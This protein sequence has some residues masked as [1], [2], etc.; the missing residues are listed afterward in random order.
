MNHPHA[1][2]LF[3]VVSAL[4]VL[5]AEPALADARC[6]RLA[7]ETEAGFE[8]AWP[9]V[10]SRVHSAFDARTDTDACARVRLENREAAIDLEVVL[11]DGRSARRSELQPEDVVPVLEGL[12]V[13]PARPFVAELP[14]MEASAGDRDPSPVQPGVD[15]ESS[16]EVVQA[17]APPPTFGYEFSLATQAR[18]GDGQI[19]AGFGASSVLE[20]ASF[21]VGLAARYDGYRWTSGGDMV[22]ALEVAA[23]GGYRFRLK[24][25]AL[26]VYGGPAWTRLQTSASS[27]APIGS[28]AV[29]PMPDAPQTF[30]P[31]FCFGAR[32]DLWPRA[33]IRSFVDLDGVIGPTGKVAEGVPPGTVSRL[34]VWMLGV[35]VGATLGTI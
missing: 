35:G 1:L 33:L 16:S 17:E 8:D 13:L 30:T 10:T 4:W 23:T 15:R 6:S 34:P 2:G 22:P 21:L 19:S 3:A 24:G 18:V 5:G 11:P 12:L 14:P 29:E 25:V 20:V 32:L 31:R 26:S 27:A 9:E 7:L 28:R